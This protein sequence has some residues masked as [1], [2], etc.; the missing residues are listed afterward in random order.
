MGGTSKGEEEGTASEVAGK[1]A[2]DGLF[3]VR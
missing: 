3:Q 1:S 2:K